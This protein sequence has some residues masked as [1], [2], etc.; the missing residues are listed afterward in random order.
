M[1]HVRIPLLCL[2]AVGFLMILAPWAFGQTFALADTLT[3]IQKPLLNIPSM[4]QPGGFLEISCAAEPSTIGWHASL[5][6][7][8]FAIPLAIQS[9]QYNPQSLWWTLTALVP[10]VPVHDLFDLRVT[11][12]G[13]I[14]DV[15]WQAVKVLPEFP[16]DFYFVHITDTHLPTYL[17]YY[18]AGADTD[19]STTI[20]LRHITRDLDIINPAFVLLT[21]DFLNEGELEDFLGEN[22]GNVIIL[23]DRTGVI[24]EVSGDQKD[25][26]KAAGLSLKRGANMDEKS[27]G[28]N[29]MGT[30]IREG[31]AVQV[32][33][34]EHFVFLTCYGHAG[35]NF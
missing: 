7:G 27:I 22:H 35:D 16:L 13:G 12:A 20:S 25:V 3:V 11:A 10:E 5:E 30:A 33:G 15:T 17:Y 6:R 9:A 31:R 29:A 34:S 19:S 14:E 26:E 24:L 2:A 4:V 28:T 18:Q 32:S 21:G 23:T 1:T 8:G